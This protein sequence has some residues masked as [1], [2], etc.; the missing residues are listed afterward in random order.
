MAERRADESTGPTSACSCWRCIE[1]RER[2]SPTVTTID[3]LVIKGFLGMVL[4]A[5]C[6]NK[7]CP[8]ANDHDLECTGSNE[9][10][11]K[12]SAYEDQK[13]PP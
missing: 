6:G 10:G 4:C 7:R 5:R 9:P 1:A 8:H 3:G 11:Q 13:W 12:G 2:V